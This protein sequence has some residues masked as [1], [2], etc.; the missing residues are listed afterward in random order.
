VSDTPL[1]PGPLYGL[2]TWRVVSDG[3][4]ELL[5]GPHRDTPWPIAGGWLE[6]A[7]GRG[8]GHTAPAPGCGCGIH[9][10]HP[11][12]ASVRRVL[13]SRREVAGIV[14]AG[15][16]VEVHEE[17]FRAERGRPHAL[18][19]VPGRNPKQIARLAATYRAEVVDVTGPDALLA[20][21]REAHVG[22][23]ES[24][25]VDLLGPAEL[26]NR[27][28]ARRWK[29]RKDAIRVAAAVLATGLLGLL[30]LTV[31]T[32][33]PGPRVLHGRTGEIHVK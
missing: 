30:G 26:E 6:S 21:C 22:L 9:A 31:L 19:L 2:R 32:D 8:A 23:D 17:G 3:G 12:R 4:R 16:A 15:G 24:V 33:P 28:R 5:A 10:W 18:L 25:V 29:T 1:V 13:A 14:E 7:C 27:R 11:R 20:W